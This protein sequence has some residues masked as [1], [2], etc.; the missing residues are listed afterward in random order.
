MS[1]DGWDR[2][3]SL[4]L[5]EVI[6]RWKERQP[7]WDKLLA[8][9][10][11]ERQDNWERFYPEMALNADGSVTVKLDDL[12][13]QYREHILPEMISDTALAFLATIYALDE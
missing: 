4:T 10:M 1:D 2:D 7:L 12:L 13:G 11:A 5:S 3:V 8:E 6:T 9:K